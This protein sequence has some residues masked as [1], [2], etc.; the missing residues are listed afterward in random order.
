MFLANKQEQSQN[1]INTNQSGV[2]QVVREPV[3]KTDLIF[4]FSMFVIVNRK[5]NN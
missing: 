2:H 3:T 4:R 5:P 1:V